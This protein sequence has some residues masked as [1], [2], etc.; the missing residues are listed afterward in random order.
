MQPAAP[1]GREGPCCQLTVASWGL[2]EA[3]LAISSLCLWGLLFL[4]SAS[5]GFQNFL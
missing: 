4:D 3:C 2:V 1:G 5:R